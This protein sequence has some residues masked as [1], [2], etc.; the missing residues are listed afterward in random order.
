ML[1][2][3]KDLLL[4]EKVKLYNNIAKLNDCEGRLLAELEVYPTPRIVWEFE[5]LGEIQC[6]FPYGAGWGIE[7]LD[8]LI[9]HLFSIKKPVCSGSS[10][11]LGPR[12]AIRGSTAEAVYGDIE[13]EA[14][15]FTFYLPNTRFQST[16]VFQ[17]RIRKSSRETNSDR[18]V[19]S[20][21]GGRYIESHLDD[22]WSIR[23]D[24]RADALAW[25]DRKNRNTGTLITTVGR[26]YQ[27][28]YKVKEPET[29]SE[30]QTMTLKNALERLKHLS[31]F[32]S[33]ANGGYI[34][35]LYIE[36]YEYAKEPLRQTSCAVSLAF[37]TTPLEQLC[38]SWVTGESDLRV[39]INYLPCFER[40]M[41]NPSWQ[42]TFDFT[43][44]QYFQATRPRTIWQVIASAAGA[45]LERLS[46]TILVE[47]ETNSTIKADC[48]LIFDIT[49][50]SAAIQ[51]WN[52]GKKP[53]QE[54]ISITGKR[55]RLLLEHIG[56][57]QS[58]G[59]NDIDDVP[60]FL[61][62]R[63]DAVHPIV[64][65]MTLEQRK[66]L[67]NQAI[68]WIDE[69]LLWRIGYSGKYL[70]RIQNPGISTTPRYDLSLRVPS[71]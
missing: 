20:E 14:H 26:L 49:Q 56:L 60:S 68:Q 34:G 35:P 40:M 31:R 24:I 21:E 63:N 25:L 38:S 52:L 36:G 54:N 12:E 55:L 16:S 66:K 19:A 13:A 9:G 69:V 65:T 41:Q 53:G 22:I 44:A 23:L 6:N 32:L 43:L 61:E 33:Y 57:T 71:W 3:H 4:K 39:Y 2:Q 7:P 48:K 64:G 29:F 47:E 30:L 10:S 45:A 67:I 70:D 15:V 59:Y 51:R 17:E 58:R 5:I 8:S 1:P 37:E 18:E 46:Y 27:P 42:E 28:K 11:S 62:V 50:K